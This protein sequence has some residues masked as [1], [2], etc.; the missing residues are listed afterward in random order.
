MLDENKFVCA[1]WRPS[2]SARV[3]MEVTLVST[4]RL[5]SCLLRQH[6]VTCYVSMKVNEHLTPIFIF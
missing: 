1:C 2:R 6:F 4:Q 3:W 5:K